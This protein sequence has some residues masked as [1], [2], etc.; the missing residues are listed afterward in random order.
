MRKELSIQESGNFADHQLGENSL[1]VMKTFRRL[2]LSDE[3]RPVKRRRTAPG[4]EQDINESTYQRIVL[5]LT[6][7][8]QETP[9]LTLSNIHNIIE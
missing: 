4:L 2:N 5:A 3:D 8:S 1:S 9:V 7:D 6:G